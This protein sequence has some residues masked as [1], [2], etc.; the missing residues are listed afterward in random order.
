MTHFSSD[1]GEQSRGRRRSKR[2]DLK[3]PEVMSLFDI[4]KEPPPTPFQIKSPTS[5]DAAKEIT[6]E[7]KAKRRD[8][9][10]KLVKGSPK[11]LARFQIARALGI[12]DHWITSSVDA[13]VKMTKIEEHPTRTVENPAS[14]VECAVLVAIDSSEMEGAA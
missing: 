9:V 11:G 12:P 2:T 14:G 7:T 13:L 5:L 4:S 6:E 1:P 10:F 8:L 3:A